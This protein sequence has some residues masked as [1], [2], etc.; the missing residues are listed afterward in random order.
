MVAMGKG[1]PGC[2]V[3]GLFPRS[4]RA[5][6]DPWGS[7]ISAY[8]W[9]KHDASLAALSRERYARALEV[10]CSVGVFTAEPK[11]DNDVTVTLA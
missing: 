1:R 2:T 11:A 4:H 10:G 7:A 8:E 3:P 9:A 5:A 6:S